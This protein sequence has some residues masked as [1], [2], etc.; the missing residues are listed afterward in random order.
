VDSSSE[1]HAKIAAA[2]IQE[3]LKDLALGVISAAM[4]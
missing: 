3:M 4:M 1:K 2:N